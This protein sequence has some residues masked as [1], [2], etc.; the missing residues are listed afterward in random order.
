MHIIGV[1][2]VRYSEV[3]VDITVLGCSCLGST[4]P[5]FIFKGT[6]I[7]NMITINPFNVRRAREDRNLIALKKTKF[8]RCKLSVS[9][10][11]KS[12]L[13]PTWGTN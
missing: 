3:D 8:R 5:T 6:N 2:D 4:S 11:E 12:S 1:Y 7:G 9:W 10:D 13:Y